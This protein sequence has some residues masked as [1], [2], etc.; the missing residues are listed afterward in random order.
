MTMSPDF[1][2][3]VAVPQPTT[4]GIPNSLAINA[5]CDNGAP[6]SVIIPPTRGKSGDHPIFVVL[7]TRISPEFR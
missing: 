3:V 6:T 2:C 7:V 1:N 5:A 4:A